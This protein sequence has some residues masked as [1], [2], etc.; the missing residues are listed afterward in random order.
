VQLFGVLLN[1]RRIDEALGYEPPSWPLQAT[2][3]VAAKLYASI[4]AWMPPMT[5]S[6]FTPGN[7]A[8]HAYPTGYKPE[9]LGPHQ[10]GEETGR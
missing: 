8:G 4:H 3:N 6:L 9:D 5:K 2:A 1:D 7:K 10:R